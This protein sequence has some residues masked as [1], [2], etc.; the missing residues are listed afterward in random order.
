MVSARKI[1]QAEVEEKKV[2]RRSTKSPSKKQ[3]KLLLHEELKSRNTGVGIKISITASPSNKKINFDNYDNDD[4]DIPSEEE[5]QPETTTEPLDDKEDVDD[6]EDDAVEEVQGQAARDQVLEQL[7]TE[8]KEALR[9]KKK[10]KRKERKE[11]EEEEVDELDDDFFAQLDTVRV[12]EEKE[13]KQEK[14]SKGKHTTFVFQ[15][16]QERTHQPKRVDHNI[17]VVVLNDNH[18][19]EDGTANALQMPINA[20][21]EAALLYSRSQLVDGTD[22]GGPLPG[23]KRRKPDASWTRS[24]KMNHLVFAKAGRGRRGMAAANFA[25]KR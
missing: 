1:K 25:T 15:Q 19:D 18:H 20:L 21:S 6:D 7:K 5:V 8:E 9:T 14:R 12:T 13:Q 22:T 3:K 16:E 17:Q 23:K 4:D 2:V 11:E 10:K 24:K